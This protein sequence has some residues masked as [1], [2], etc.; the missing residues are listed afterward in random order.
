MI[1][2]YFE[3]LVKMWASIE[4]IEGNIGTGKITLLQM[5]EQSLSGED[6]V[7]VK[8]EHEPVK[9]FQSFMEIN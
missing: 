4:T 3:E 6:K 1:H 8:V 9:E 2:D 5:F 7:T